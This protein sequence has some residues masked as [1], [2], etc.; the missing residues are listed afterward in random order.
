MKEI[1]EYTEDW[2]KSDFNKDN[3]LDRAEVLDLVERM[4]VSGK[5]MFET[6]VLMDLNILH[7]ERTHPPISERVEKLA[8][9][10]M[11]EKS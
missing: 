5:K 1:K 9:V 4:K 7:D 2:R 8:S 10:F 3:Y 6:E 11:T